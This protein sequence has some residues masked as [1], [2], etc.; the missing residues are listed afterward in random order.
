MPIAVVVEG[1]C[2]V[3]VNTGSAGAL[4]DLGYSIDGVQVTEETF[5][6]DVP[7]DQNR[8]TCSITARSTACVWN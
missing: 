6:S 5:M 8:S 1:P 2:L 3:Q 7:G 4:E